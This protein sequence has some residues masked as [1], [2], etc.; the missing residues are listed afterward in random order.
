MFLQGIQSLNFDSD[1]LPTI[2]TC[3]GPWRKA[4]VLAME[5]RDII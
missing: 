4:F 1:H 3:L 2:F 5:D